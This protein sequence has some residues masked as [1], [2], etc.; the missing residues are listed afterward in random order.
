MTLKRFK[1]KEGVSP[2]QHFPVLGRVD[3]STQ[4]DEFVEKHKD[5]ISHLVEEVKEKPAT[6]PAK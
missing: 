4:T 5:I 3:I 2:I 6:T 1:V